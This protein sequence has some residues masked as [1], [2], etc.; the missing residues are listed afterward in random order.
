MRQVVHGTGP[1]FVR[2]CHS[3]GTSTRNASGTMKSSQRH[4]STDQSSLVGATC[5]SAVVA[6]KLGGRCGRLE[7]FPADAQGGS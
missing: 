3:Q 1:A 5:W 2:I 7:D 4:Y 6:L